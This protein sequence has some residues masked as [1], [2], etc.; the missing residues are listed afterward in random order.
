MHKKT[1]NVIRRGDRVKVVNPLLVTRVGYPLSQE[2]VIREHMD[3]QDKA[4]LEGWLAKHGIR[5]AWNELGSSEISC[6]LYE[7]ESDKII[8]AMARIIQHSKRYGGNIRSVHKIEKPDLAGK[9]LQVISKRVVYSGVRVVDESAYLT[10]RQAHI[11][12]DCRL[13]NPSLLWDTY[14]IFRIEHCDII[15]L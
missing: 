12:Y 4:I 14:D 15:K 9:T 1:D 2:T 6:S 5:Y 13:Y 7:Q 8:R 10:N 3:E 11:I